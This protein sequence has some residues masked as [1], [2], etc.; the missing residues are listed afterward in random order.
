MHLIFIHLAG[1][2]VTFDLVLV[3]KQ[4]LQPT[5]QVELHQALPFFRPVVEEAAPYSQTD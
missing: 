5:S 3:A 2:C 1:V 4:E